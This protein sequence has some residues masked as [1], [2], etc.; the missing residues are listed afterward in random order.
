MADN[1]SS[2][3]KSVS[4]PQEEEGYGQGSGQGYGAG[5]GYGYGSG[6][7]YPPGGG[8]YGGTPD[9]YGYGYGAGG[10]AGRYG[11]GYGYGSYGY[12]GY[13]GYGR[14]HSEEGGERPAPTIRDYLLMVRERFWYLVLAIFIC[15]TSGFVYVANTTDQFRAT[16]QL[17][18]Y[19]TPINTPIIPGKS[20]TESVATPDDLGTQIGSMRTERIRD[21]VSKRIPA[22][23]RS[24]VMDPYRQNGIFGGT[25]REGDILADCSTIASVRGTMIVEVSYV[26]P[27]PDIALRMV[28]YFAEEI[29]EENEDARQRVSNPM[30]E[31][32]RNALQGLTNKYEDLLK[33]RESMYRGNRQLITVDA[34][35]L[36]NNDLAGQYTL[37]QAEKRNFQLTEKQRLQ[38]EDM[39]KRAQPLTNLTMFS[40]DSTVADLHRQKISS[41]IQLQVML[42]QLGLKNPE[43][44][45]LEARL[46][47]TDAQLNAAIKVVKD[48]FLESWQ[49]TKDRLEMM[50]A[51]LIAKEKEILITYDDKNKLNNLNRLIADNERLRAGME[52]VMEQEKIRLRGGLLPNIDLLDEP[53]L[54]SMKPIN[55]DWLRWGVLGVATG[56][57][58]GLAIIF[59]LAFLDDRVKSSMDIEGFLRLPLVGVLPV[60]RR[61]SSFKKARIVESGEDRPLLEAFRSVYSSLRINETARSAKAILLTSTS[62][63]EG[64]SF[65]STN[66][67]ITFASQGEKVL[68]IDCD[69]RVP[70]VGKTLQLKGNNGITK[71]LLNQVALEDAIHYSVAKNLDVLPVG[72]PCENPTQVLTSRKFVDMIT[73]LKGIYDRIIID[74][75]PIGAVS[76]VLNMLPM[77]DGV[78]YVV[79]FNTVKKRFIRSNIARLRE[80]K[81][82][83]FGAILNHIGIRVAQYYTNTGDRSYNRYYA[84][85]NK[86]AVTVTGG[87]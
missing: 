48:R 44:I 40:T 53:H 87:E 84:K 72:Q 21:R 66:M 22:E 1:N 57:A 47:E 60:A 58:L 67:A 65:V 37:L 18:L 36:L 86:D 62:P 81:V 68:L 61:S 41:V 79:R 56:I 29:R 23:L 35:S 26:H 75:P 85:A 2:D 73:T 59:M 71:Y 8:Y 6:Y 9:G 50:E 30:L 27:K 38:I 34:P 19:R 80:T 77:V 64:K 55:K 24:S 49:A 69:L 43:V 82:P 14:G 76:D 31:T 70:V 25:R 3:E 63:S 28:R 74:S 16:A 10:G 42:K 39:E 5:Y 7:G 52:I 11:N 20:D 4:I 51:N 78:L 12:G 17:R 33:E 45:A 83:I 15:T 54:F 13:G 46:L 32:A